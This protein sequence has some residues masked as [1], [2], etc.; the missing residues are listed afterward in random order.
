MLNQVITYVINILC[1][2]VMFFEGIVFQF[3]SYSYKLFS[4][5]CQLNFN[6][7]YAIISPLIDRLQAVIIVLVVY[8]LATTLIGMMANPESAP[9]AGTE[10]IKNIAITVVL[11]I[12]YNLIFSVMNEI[13]MLILGAPPGYSYTVLNELAGVTGGE[14]DEGLIMRFVFGEKTDIG[15]VGDYIAFETMSIFLSNTTDTPEVENALYDGDDG[16]NFMNMHTLAPKIGKT[17]SYVPIG[18]LLIAA[19]L[20][21]T[22]FN[23]AAEIGTRVFKLIVLQML[24]PLAIITI[25]SDGLKS[26]VWKKFWS[27]YLSV[28]K[29]I[30]I[31]I[32]S[33]LIVTVLVS[34]FI[35]NLGDFFGS[36]LIGDDWL[37]NGLLLAIVVFAGYKFVLDAPKL[38]DSLFGSNIAG[39]KGDGFSS[40][41][42]GMIAGGLTGM[43]GGAM[44]GGNVASRIGGAL[45]GGLTGFGQGFVNGA[46]GQ[47]I[48]DAIKNTSSSSHKRTDNW[49][50]RGGFG[51]VTLA[52]L[53][54]VSGR[55]KRQDKKMN[56]YQAQMDAVTAFEEAE[57]EYNESVN[58]AQIDAIK[59]GHAEAS[60][61][62][63]TDT[64]GNLYS[65]GY[66]TVSLGES[67][68]GYAQR[69]L[70]YD[71]SYQSAQAALAVQQKSGS[72]ADIAAAQR[73]VIETRN[74]ANKRAKDYWE[75]KKSSATHSVDSKKR[76]DALVK[77][78]KE[79]NRDAEVRR[80]DKDAIDV[81]TVKKDINSKQKKIQSTKG[82]KATHYEKK[83]K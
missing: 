36:A 38:I 29:D 10:L 31:R 49:K 46:K 59:G 16:Y 4:L 25:I 56:M 77:A 55:T 70:E 64:A 24:A 54:D 27:T 75:S 68:E 21:Y 32:L 78:N 42:G 11:L 51:Q 63:G 69:M 57:K 35:A 26:S 2:I 18:G 7:L 1:Q 43:V 50:E 72:E 53:N 33:T 62:F 12:T 65:S 9:K 40:A 23:L 74:E 30:F 80:G 8:K 79:L 66:E 60:D 17:V 41:L 5:M 13:S 47:N 37:T 82:Y 81:K 45:A 73:K 61:M 83:D 34:K 22:F 19:F 76:D 48:A 3:A 71:K 28:Y 58:K 6:S 15:D 44:A 39:S 14:E 67:A 20:V 52:G